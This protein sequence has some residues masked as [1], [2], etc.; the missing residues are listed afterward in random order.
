[1]AILSS[2]SDEY[3]PHRSFEPFDRN[4]NPAAVGR[5]DPA[6]EDGIRPQLVTFFAVHARCAQQIGLLSREDF[7]T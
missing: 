7:R 2:A 6:H 4:A 3:V 1:M 5:V